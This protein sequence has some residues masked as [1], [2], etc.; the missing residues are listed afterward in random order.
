MRTTFFGLN[1]GVSGLA[2]QQRALEITGHNIANANTEGFTRQEAVITSNMPVKTANGFVGTGVQISDVR[3][4]R[5]NYLDFQIRTENKTSGYWEQKRDALQKVEVIINEPSDAGLRSV[6]DEFWSGWEDL[7]REPESSA[8]RITVVQRGE[9]LVETFN[10]MDRQLGEL[11]EDIDVSLKYKVDD[12]NSLA[13]QIKDLN[14]QIV[15]GEAEGPKVNDLRDKRD[16]LVD[17]LSKLVDIES[18]ENNRGAILVTIGGR[19]LVFGNEVMPLE[20]RPDV[21]NNGFYEISWSD[22][23]DVKICSGELKGML[24]ARDEITTGFMEKLDIMAKALAEEVNAIHEAG[25]GKN[26]ATGIPFFAKP[27]IGADFSAGNIKMNDDIVN[28]TDNI[29]AASSSVDDPLNNDIGDGSNAL[30]IAQVKH[31][32]TLI[33]NTS[34]EDFYRSEVSHLGIETQEAIRMVE[35]QDL[36]VAQLENKRE[37]VMGVSIDEEMTNMIRFQHAYNSAARYITVVDEMLDVLV[38]RLGVVGR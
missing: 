28:N 11:R 21:D 32:S 38:N 4:I 17:K 36:L 30:K 9:A 13:V 3:R 1:I 18:V 26:N 15:K 2:A 7:S 31:D 20:V 6:M 22:G 24:E 23:I 8:A 10:H 12:I 29:A 35:N 19:A 37:M 5:D 33:G 27:D 16:L 14:Y 25:Y 34:F